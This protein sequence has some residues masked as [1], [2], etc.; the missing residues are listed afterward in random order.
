VI[1]VGS[2]VPG[3]LSQVL[4]Q[5]GALVQA[6]QPIARLQSS[7]EAATVAL[8][9]AQAQSRSEIEAQGARVAL[10]RKK[11]ER[12]TR[13]VSTNIVAQQDVDTLEAELRIAE[14][15]LARLNEQQQLQQ[16]DLAR[17]SAALDVRT[18]KSPIQGVVTEKALSGGEYVSEAGHIMTIA[19]VDP[20]YVET[21]LPVKL[22]GQIKEGQTATVEV[23]AP[24]SGRY[25]ARVQVVDHVFDAASSTFGVR[26]TLAN[27]GGEVP[28][29]LH[30]KVAFQPKGSFLPTSVQK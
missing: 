9:R 5:R 18:I 28:A 24:L 20:L 16:L 4:V 14:Q 19:A 3:Q 11:L 15:D 30:C 25:E 1:K 7:V 21:F 22:Y 6:G 17:A 8:A 27:P 26:L 13:L 29:G 12:A 10:S 2:P 23:N